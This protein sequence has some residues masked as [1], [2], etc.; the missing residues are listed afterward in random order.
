MASSDT[1]LQVELVAADRTVWSG[2]ASMVIARTVEGDVGVLR[3]H[4]PLLSLLTDAVVEI[5]APE[6]VVVAAVDGG[7]LS[8]AGD[9]VSV[10]SE[11][12]VLSEE[13]DVD[14]ARTELDEARGLPTSDEAE[15][16]IRRAE[17]RI[18]AVEKAR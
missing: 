17:A 11:H 18:R 3:G 1:G 9:R 14:N 13:I 4:A 5:S 10:L 6:G 12:A 15:Q 16:R 2:E 8:V 7:F